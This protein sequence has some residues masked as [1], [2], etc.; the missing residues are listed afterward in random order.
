[1]IIKF[2]QVGRQ[3]NPNFEVLLKDQVIAKGIGATQSNSA[4]IEIEENVYEISDNIHRDKDKNGKT[5]TQV[6]D[7]VKNGEIV[8]RIYPDIVP[9]KKILFISVGYDYFVIDLYENQY[10]AYEVGLGEN[11]HYICIYEKNELVAIIHKDDK[12]INFKDTYTIYC[13]DEKLLT[14][15]CIFN[16]YFDITNYP[17]HGEIMDQHIEHGGFVTVNKELNSKFDPAFIEKVRKLEDN[18]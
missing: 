8:G 7:I 13:Q 16:L 9:Q 12:V 6:K 15:L 11:Q 2:N 3:P 4:K 18:K 5:I 10:F 14:M 1:M 17:N